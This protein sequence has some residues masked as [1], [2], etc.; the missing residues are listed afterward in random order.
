[1]IYALTYTFKKSQGLAMQLNSCLT[2]LGVP[3]MIVIDRDCTIQPNAVIRYKKNYTG[4]HGWSDSMQKIEGYKEALKVWDIKD[5]DWLMDMDDDTYMASGEWLKILR[6]Q[7]GPG[8]GHNDL[9]GIQHDDPFPTAMGMFAHMSGACL[10]MKGWVV[11]KLVALDW[12]KLARDIRSY[13]LPLV[14]DLVIS[15][16]CVY[17]GAKSLAINKILDLSVSFEDFLK[18]KP[19]HFFHFNG[20]WKQLMGYPLPNGR[21]DIPGVLEKINYKP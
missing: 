8:E 21:Y 16:G 17:A 1:M 15:Y 11:K 6:R 10:C 18:G 13:N 9:A 7:E 3:H 19:G 12:N 4:G 5:D 2:R 20:E 14:W